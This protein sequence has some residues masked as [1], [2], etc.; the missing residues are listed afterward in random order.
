[1]S[2]HYTSNSRNIS[3]EILSRTWAR[4]S[5]WQRMVQKAFLS[6]KSKINS[7]RHILILICIITIQAQLIVPDHH[8]VKLLEHSHPDLKV[9]NIHFFHTVSINGTS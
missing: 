6:I 9:L 4:I 1:M 2:S 8:K 7:H 3:R 5:K